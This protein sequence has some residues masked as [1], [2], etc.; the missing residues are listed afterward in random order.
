MLRGS[1]GTHAGVNLFLG[2]MRNGNVVVAANPEVGRGLRT[3][4]VA[5]EEVGALRCC[6]PPDHAC[7]SRRRIGNSRKP[8][9]QK[10]LNGEFGEM[11]SEVP[12]DRNS[13]IELKIGA[14]HVRRLASFDENILLLCAGGMS[15]GDIQ[16]RL[17]RA[18]RRRKARR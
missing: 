5:G 15:T 16:G 11:E 3:E 10:P 12:P 17:R 18:T 6:E 7:V 13:G 1:K 9:K 14:L 4:A 2:N 8:A